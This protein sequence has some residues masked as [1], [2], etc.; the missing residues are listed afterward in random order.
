VSGPARLTPRWNPAGSDPGLDDVPDAASRLTREFQLAWRRGERPTVERFLARS[1]AADAE[2]AIQLIC[3]EICLRQESGEQ[4]DAGELHARFPHWRAELELLLACGEMFADQAPPVLPQPGDELGEFR[5]LTE[6]GRGANGRVFL[7]TQPALS[8]RQVV[9]KFTSSTAAEHLSLARLQH[10]GIVPL[11]L[12]QHFPARGLRG[13]CMPYL[14]GASLDTLLAD[15]KDQPP[16]RRSGRSLVAALDRR[17]ADPSLLLT[18]PATDA[19]FLET[20]G[21]VEA[22]C[23]IGACLADALHY[24]HQR[25]LVHL[26]V[27]PSN[28]LLAADR[29]P[30]LLDFHLARAPL[31][32]GAPADEWLGGTPGYMSPEQAAALA[33]IRGGGGVAFPV[34]ARSDVFSLGVLLYEALGGQVTA[35]ADVAPRPPLA[36]RNACVT[37]GLEDLLGKCLRHEPRDRY[38]DAAALA[39]DLRRHLADLPLRGVANRSLAERW[40]KWRRRKPHSLARLA[41]GGA[42]AFAFVGG[43][44]LMIGRQ[45][46]DAQRALTEGED[47][48]ER[49]VFPA[50]IDRLRAGL[51]RLRFVPGY[52]RLKRDLDDR[53]DVAKWRNFAGD[54]HRLVEQLRFLDCGPPDAV[55][56]GID[57]GCRA[58]WAARDQIVGQFAHATSGNSALDLSADGV[59]TDAAFAG[60]MRT[61][62]L[63]LAI[64][65]SGLRV[66]RTAEAD[67]A[68]LRREALRLLAE[69]EG[70]LG[71]DP[72]LDA[73]R[74][75]HTAALQGIDAPPIAL[76]AA[77]H[78][79]WEHDA[80]GRRMM[81][82][83]RLEAASD[84]FSRAVEE[85]PQAFWPNFHLGVC[86]YRLGRHEEALRSFCVCVALAPA[87]AECFYNRGLAYAARD[88]VM[89]ALGDYGRALQCDSHFA[90][91]A[92]RRAA[93]Y[94]REKQFDEAAAD[95]KRA[96]ADGADPAEVDYRWA[97]VHLARHDQ[98]AAV[99]R[100]RAALAH[101]PGHRDA[102]M[103]LERL[104]ATQGKVY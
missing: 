14:G 62:L 101:A 20:S 11:Y 95:L 39:D 97:L 84:E 57:D 16:E 26:D 77:L 81:H 90:V 31:P 67:V 3:E 55:P 64:L 9:V 78:S 104:R 48:L 35:G 7:A 2:L 8:D 41:L 76:G 15:L 70:V 53:I 85:T 40:R 37:R 43:G 88:Q 5:L 18:V 98:Q 45:V 10:T 22:V 33:A 61:D 103:L 30:M 36:E 65:W 58:I 69:A 91:A 72:A 47:L 68:G 17:Q 24:A 79:D 87:S 50:A 102:Q 92:L 83:G 38:P 13:L 42:L 32:A 56:A 54:L 27:K 1:P 59:S 71:S 86:R 93:L 34:D 99:A 49:G 51:D 80:L 89:E 29:Q 23:W 6:L 100:L 21:Y 12:V 4:V 44:P 94:T 60:Q 96:A 52:V 74:A 66:R 46:H 63:D 75:S 19:Q 82:E 28:V 25:G 73:E